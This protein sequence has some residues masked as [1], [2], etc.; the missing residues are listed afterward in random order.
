M[1][2]TRSQLASFLP[3]PES[4]REFERMYTQTQRL[5]E[6]GGSDALELLATGAEVNG[7]SALDRLARVEQLL[8][9]VLSGPSREH[10]SVS[11]DYIDMTEVGPHV[12]LPRRIQWNQDDGTLDVGL[13]NGVV[14]QVGQEIHYYAK[15]TSGVTI[16]NGSSVMATGAVGSSGKLAVAKAVADGTVA[17]DYMIGVAT[18]DIPDGE[19][20]YVTAYGLVRGF[21]T[22][23]APYGETW[24]D[25]DVLYFN[26]SVPGGLTKVAPVAPQLRT[27]IAIVINAGSGGSGSIFVRIK[28]GDTL[29]GLDD[30]HT[31]APWDLAY[32]AWNAAN[33]R[34]ENSTVW[35]DVDFPVIIRT[36]GPNIPVLAT[37]QGNITAPQWAINDYTVLEAQELPHS[38]KEGSQVRIHV[39]FLTNGLDGTD[40][41]VNWEVEWFWVNMD[42]QASTTTISAAELLIPANTP[43]RTMIAG[44]IATPTLTGGKIASHFFA[45][46]RRIAVTTP[47]RVEPTNN[48]WCWMMQLHIECDTQGSRNVSSK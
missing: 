13:L 17:S 23:G 16:P 2:F 39:H 37:V 30:V 3:D 40:R 19:F 4:V 26:P 42:G 1:R 18:Q 35:I 36:T 41:Y 11:T 14:M 8:Q 15:N 27:K 34:W 20:G 6:V 24:N 38:W 44:E 22:T 29:K 21:D 25:G 32:P 47:G 5:E 31:P 45:R 48:P 28:V 46:L 12:T 9:M 43:T 7:V 33:K 10:N